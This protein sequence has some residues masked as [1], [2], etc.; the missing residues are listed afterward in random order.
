MSN[1]KQQIRPAIIG[2]MGLRAKAALYFVQDQI[3]F[4]GQT[5]NGQEHV[6]FLSTATLRQAFA[7]EPVDSGWLPAGINRCG[8]CSR[9]AW[10][11][12][13][14]APALYTIYLDGRKSP[15]KVP[16]PSLI[17][18]GIRHHYYIFAAREKAFSPKARL[19]HAPLANVGD[20]GLICFGQNPHPDVAKGGFD[21]AWRTFWEAPFNNHHDD[22]KSKAY[23]ESVNDQLRALARRRAKIYPTADLVSLG[24]TLEKAIDLLTWRD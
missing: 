21:P 4:H 12:R 22:G 16:M 15:I 9:G 11:V 13:W 6:K 14:N 19:Y 2:P 7:N 3:L 23:P 5:D 18:F 17:W 1:R 8:T 20:L 10:M 24:T